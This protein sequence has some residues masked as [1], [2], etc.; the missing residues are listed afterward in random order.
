MKKQTSAINLLVGKN[1]ANKSL[2]IHQAVVDLLIEKGV[3][4][5]EEI[6]TRIDAL[7]KEVDKKDTFRRSI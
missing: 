4:T 1:V 2:I 6:Q 5:A 7:R 3:L